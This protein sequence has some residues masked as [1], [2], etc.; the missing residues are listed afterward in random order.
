MTCTIWGRKD[1][2][3]TRTD[4][5]FML[6]AMLS[7]NPVNTC[8]YLLDYLASVGAMFESRAEIVV[9]GI[10]TFIARKF[11]VGEDKGINS[12]EGNNRLNIDTL[13]SMNFI[14]PHPPANI[15]YELKLN[16][17]LLF[18]LPNPSWTNTEVEANLL[19]VG[20]DPQVHE[21]HNLVEEEGA[22]LHHDEEHHDHEADG[23]YDE[24]DGHG[25]KRRSRG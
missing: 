17:P 2:G 11:I 20:V 12:I 7:N 16:V 24:K 13:I 4:E 21:E 8:Y 6:W 14:K 19:Y 18:I 15:T 10:I 25:C 9:G 5:L 1:V 22:H 3:T 23:P